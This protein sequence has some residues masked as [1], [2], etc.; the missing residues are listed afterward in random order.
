M[1]AYFRKYSRAD[2]SRGEKEDNQKA[3][4][5]HRHAETIRVTMYADWKRIAENGGW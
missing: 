4:T 3:N 1:E 5:W 2:S